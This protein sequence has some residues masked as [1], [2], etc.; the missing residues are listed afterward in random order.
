MKSLYSILGIGPDATPAQIEAAY[1]E[2][3]TALQEGSVNQQG[4]D[5]RT[6]LIAIK[7][8][9]SILS[10]PVSR[11]RYNQKLFAP[12]IADSF[13]AGNQV[14]ISEAADSGGM[15]KILVVG[16]IALSGLA[17]YAYNARERDQLRIQHER[18]VQLK[19][20]Q[21]A[22]ERQKL[23]AYE[24]EV[25][26]ERQQKYDAE[27]QA[28]LQKAED[29]RYMRD[30]DAR[31]RS[32]AREAEQRRQR[33]NY[34]KKLQEREVEAQHRREIMEAERRVAKDKMELQRIER[35]RSSRYYSR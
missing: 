25:R 10:D 29:E 4:N 21:L 34:E 18:E 3:L 17:L 31:Q 14:A 12:E 28:R 11:Q 33:E 30:F 8:A 15:K 16:A 2:L 13:S 20:L 9:Y 23:A 22:E 7:E 5:S 26:M 27:T 32:E 19:A 1:A 35:E 6:R 24:Q